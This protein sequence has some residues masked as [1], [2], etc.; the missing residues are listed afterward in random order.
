MN[1]FPVKNNWLAK[2]YPW[3]IWTIAASFFFYKYLLQVSP[4]VMTSDLMSAF[5]VN[6]AGLGNLSA[7]YF[8]S[9]LIMQIPVGV[10]LDRYSPRLLTTAAL[11]LCS[12]STFVFAQTDS[13]WLACMSRA[14]MGAG[15]AFAAVSCFKIAALWFSPKRFAL[16]SGM[17]MTAAMLGAVGGQVPLS[18]LVQSV[19]WRSALQ[20]VSFLGILLGLLYFLVLRD[21]PSS[22][23]A[24]LK[25]QEPVWHLLR[26]IITNRQ[27]WAL[28]LYS[29]LAFAPVSVFGG[30]WGVPFLEKAYHLSRTDS[31]LAISFIFIGFAAGAPFWGWLSDF[32]QK[33]KPV[34]FI[35]TGLALFSLL[36]VLYSSVLYLT[37]LSVLLFC[38]GFCASGFFTSF[39]MIRELFP[40]ILVATVLGIMNTFNSVFEALFEPLVGLLLD[41]SRGDA[42]VNG[43]HQFSL[44]G[45]YSALLILPLSLGLSLLVLLLIDETYCRPKEEMK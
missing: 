28:S 3:I 19:G 26:R 36:L 27:A 16:V 41:W 10:M 32:I 20:I 4:S 11:M 40:L 1:T 34:L 35:G 7:F 21:K 22:H 14:L 25:H 8:Y 37:S 30:L 33:R 45:Y 42:V 29:G 5:H 31:A 39:A 12:I 17:F 15:A 6:A 13:L 23:P 9:Y 43:M 24:P 44:H 2:I 38:F 18:L